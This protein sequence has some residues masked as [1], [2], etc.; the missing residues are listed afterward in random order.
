[1]VKGPKLGGGG[2]YKIQFIPRVKENSW[3]IDDIGKFGMFAAL[4]SKTSF[5]LDNLQSQSLLTS[6]LDLTSIL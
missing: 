3:K 4:E 1:M 2:V 6:A 5:V